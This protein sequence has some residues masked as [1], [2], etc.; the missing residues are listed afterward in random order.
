MSPIERKKFSGEG[1]FLPFICV[2]FFRLSSKLNGT[3]NPFSPP[4]A[5]EDFFCVSV[6]NAPL[7]PFFA[8]S[9]ASFP[10]A[11]SREGPPLFLGK[12]SS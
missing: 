8:C 9:G 6:E 1:T 10:F 12:V 2:L 11:V 7:L 5:M 3:A 4:E